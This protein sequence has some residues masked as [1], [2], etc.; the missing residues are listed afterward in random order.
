[1]TLKKNLLLVSAALLLLLGRQAVMAKGIRAAGHGQKEGDQYGLTDQ[2]DRELWI[3]DGHDI[4]NDLALRQLF[5]FSTEPEVIN[6]L[7]FY[8]SIDF[9]RGSRQALE[10]VSCEL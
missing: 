8:S 9:R 3:E 1:M 7:K 5:V 10:E 4:I 2:G 6:F